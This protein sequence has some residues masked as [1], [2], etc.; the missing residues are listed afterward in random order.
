MKCRSREI[1]YSMIVQEILNEIIELFAMATSK[2]TETVLPR[3]L[4]IKGEVPEHQLAAIYEPMIGMVVQGRK[5]ISIGT[6]VIHLNPPSYFVIPT[7]MPVTGYVQQ[8][9]NGFPY[10]SV[11]LQLNQNILLD[12]LKDVPE[13]MQS[14][15]ISNDFSACLASSEFLDAWL[16]MLRLMKTPE[17]IPALAPAYEREILYHVLIGPEGWRLRQL[18]QA[19]R[20][21]SSIHH[22]IQWVRQNF[23]ESFE[24]DHLADRACMGTTTFHRQFKQITGLSP[25]QYQKQL[26]LH[27]A[28]K[29]LIFSGYSVTDAAFEVGY[30]STSQFNR[31]YARLFGASPAR[32]AKELKKLVN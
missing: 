30:E 24:I 25:I 10:L 32:D 28:R 19:Q 21:G 2:P 22:A 6:Q 27:E 18:F 14:E 11:G 9:P 13:T 1:C 20:K 29:L 5:T 15:K 31:E 17:H 8:G 4:I 3:I 26:R 12:L 23:S 16:R 7:E